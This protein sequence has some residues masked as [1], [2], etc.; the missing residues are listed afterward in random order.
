MRNVVTRLDAARN[1]GLSSHRPRK[2]KQFKM[3]A[4]EIFPGDDY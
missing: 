3:A 4:L 1:A 2:M